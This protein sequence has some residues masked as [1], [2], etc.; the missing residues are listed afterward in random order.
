[1]EEH[2]IRRLRKERKLNLETVAEAAGVSV[3]QMSRIET[4]KR[5]AR[6][7]ELAMLAEFFGVPV[8]ALYS[9]Q[10][11]KDEKVQIKSAPVVGVVQAGLWYDA[12]IP[13]QVNDDPIPYVPTRFKM[14]DQ[15]AY[16]VAGPSMN[17]K[18]INDGDYILVV[19]Y[20]HVRTSPQDG[21]LA[22]IER[23]RDNGETERT[24]KEIVV[25]REVIK[26]MPRSSDPAFRDPIVIPRDRAN[27]SYER[28][29]IVALVIGAY[30]SFF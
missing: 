21:D 23:S 8:G 20:W 4:G 7:D 19:P 13:P 25:E 22:V 12:S 15:F 24:V 10:D 3:S 5:Q 11:Y 6:A 9:A 29:E 18:G 14:H 26:L 27:D 28:V 30:R 2:P 1:M 16:R 17:L